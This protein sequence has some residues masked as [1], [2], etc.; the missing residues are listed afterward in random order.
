MEFRR[1]QEDLQD[2]LQMEECKKG[3]QTIKYEN[4]DE[5]AIVVILSEI[6]GEH[7]IYEPKDIPYQFW[8]SN[9]Y[10]APEQAKERN[11][12]L[13]EIAQW[14]ISILNKA[15]VHDFL[16]VVGKEHKSAVEAVRLYKEYLSVSQE[17]EANFVAI[18]R[19][20]SLKVSIS[21]KKTVDEDYSNLVKWILEQSEST[22]YSKRYH[23]LRTCDE[24]KILPADELFTLVED[25]LDSIACGSKEIHF[26]ELF[27]AL[28]EKLYAEKKNM[29]ATKLKISDPVVMK[30]RRKK[31]D[32]YIALARE[33]T[34]DSPVD[35]FRY[36][37]FI[38]KAVQVLKQIAG[39][40]DERKQLLREIEGIQREA[41]AKIPVQKF[42]MNHSEAIK[43]IVKRVENLDKEEGLCYFALFIPMLNAK[44]LREETIE[45]FKNNPLMLFGSSILDHNGKKKAVLPDV[46]GKSN[47]IKEEA[48]WAYMAKDSYISIDI[49]S[50]VV[51]ANVKHI[52]QSNYEITEQDIRKI[53]E[54]SVFVPEDRRVAYTKGLMAGFNSDFLT[55]LSI[56]MPQV[57]NSIR[58]FAEMCG[59]VVYNI[60]EDN[61]EELKSMNAV[62]DLPKVKE[63]FDES[64]WFSLNTVFCS[65]YGLN[66]RNEVAHGT[67]NDKYFSS[68][69]ALYVWWFVFKLCYM[70]TRNERN[71][72]CERVAQKVEKIME[73]RQNE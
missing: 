52:L 18:N 54:D 26:I 5:K 33:C 11:K 28:F 47:E 70:Y 31:A 44:S 13:K 63:C 37:N 10:D 40:E 61:T 65:K 3:L 32:G 36:V 50:K 38:Q 66:M 58:V 71:T 48:L 73:D 45:M 69:R 64:L 14:D 43:T 57:D 60:K 46:F 4:D 72:Y 16:W 1:I 19:L 59:E 39:T 9:W 30:A 49:D 2:I 15:K 51:I 53:V 7:L 21:R 29:V 23:L 24:Y 67:L 12:A 17:F 25:H 42:S 55:A 22:D 56:L 62:L 34:G 41:S 8:A 20:I 27:V 6:V 68:Y 35:M